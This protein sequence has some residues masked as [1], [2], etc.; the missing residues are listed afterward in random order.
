MDKIVIR[1]YS[2]NTD[3]EPSL[4]LF[5]ELLDYESK[6]DQLRNGNIKTT[7]RYFDETLTGNKSEKRKIFVAQLENKIVG[8]ISVAI[9]HSSSGIF[10]FKK[11]GYIR[12]MVVSENYRRRN[13]GKQLIQKAY[14]YFAKIGLKYVRVEAIYSN[15]PAVGFYKS[16][17]FKYETIAFIKKL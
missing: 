13:V 1:D 7:Q 16:E 11:Y 4:K 10:K 2:Y 5:N 9:E 17:G 8:L 3:Y 15:N 12:D 6:L 14:E